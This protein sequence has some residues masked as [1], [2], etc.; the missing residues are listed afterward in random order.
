[1]LQSRLSASQLPR[2]QDP[3]A[4]RAKIVLHSTARINGRQG[5]AR[6]MHE[7]RVHGTI[8]CDTASVIKSSCF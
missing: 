1:M 5:N 2:Q 3:T 4:K 7:Q 6:P 8:L